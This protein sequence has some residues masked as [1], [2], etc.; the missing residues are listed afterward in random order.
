MT[1]RLLP[2]V[3]E[4]FDPTQM[5]LARLVVGA[6]SNLLPQ[7]RNARHFKRKLPCIK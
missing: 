3:P 4:K 5:P 6:M 1:W 7:K 2:W